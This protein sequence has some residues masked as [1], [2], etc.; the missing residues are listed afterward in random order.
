[1]KSSRFIVT[2]ADGREMSV[3]AL[4]LQDA[5]TYAYRYGVV[6]RVVAG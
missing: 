1:M 3:L 4:D 5:W 6:V 2:F